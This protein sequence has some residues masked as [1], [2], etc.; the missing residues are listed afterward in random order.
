MLFLR[1]SSNSGPPTFLL[2]LASLPV[3]P[4]VNVCIYMEN[5]KMPNEME[6]MLE[7]WTITIIMVLLRVKG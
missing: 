1:I 7:L 2:N 6:V 5:W 4:N 3:L